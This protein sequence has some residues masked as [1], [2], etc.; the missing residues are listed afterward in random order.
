MFKAMHTHCQTVYRIV[1]RNLEHTLS[2]RLACVKFSR[3]LMH[4]TAVQNITG[5]EYTLMGIH[6]F[7]IRQYRRVKVQKFNLPGFYKFFT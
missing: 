7:L 6:S 1:V 2:K 4:R 3:D 5:I